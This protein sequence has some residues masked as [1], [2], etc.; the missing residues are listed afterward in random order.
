LGNLDA[1]QITSPPA[2]LLG[3]R[4]FHQPCGCPPLGK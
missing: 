2:P 4:A 3:Y 1:D